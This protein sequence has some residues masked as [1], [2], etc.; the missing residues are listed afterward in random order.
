M[1]KLKFNLLI[2]PAALA[3]SGCAGLGGTLAIDRFLDKEITGDTYGA[4]MAR[5]YQAWARHKAWVQK[6]YAGAV[7]LEA[8]A[9][10]AKGRSG[11]STVF[12]CDGAPAEETSRFDRFPA[13]VANDPAKACACGNAAV[14]LE[15]WS[16]A[17]PAD[18]KAALQKRF[19]AAAKACD[20]R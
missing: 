20:G 13:I 16:C 19:E 11:V 6:N 9:D 4:C 15:R 14:E 8:R 10:A 1:P 17:G 12:V 2:M 18:D 7:K 5:T 3:L